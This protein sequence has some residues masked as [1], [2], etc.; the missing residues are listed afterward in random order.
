MTALDWDVHAYFVLNGALHDAAIAAWEIKRRDAS[1]RPITLIRVMGRYGQSSDPSLP[2][3]HTSGLPLVPGLIEL[4]TSESI[5]SGRHVGLERHLGK[6]VVRGWRGEPGDRVRGVGGVTWIRAVEWLPYQRRTFVTPAFPGY[7]SG[8]STFSR[9]ASEV[10][11]AI[12]G[13][14][15]FPGGYAYFEAKPG[16]LTFEYGPSAPVRLEWASYFDAADQAGQSRLWGGIHVTPDDFR[17]R[18]LGSRV[19]LNALT[20]ARSFF[21]P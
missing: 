21:A 18:V 19:G 12:T 4:V 8:H 9:A 17:G 11:S 15:Y 2:S 14:P 16:Y 6:V 5:A 1:A 3:Y 10:L 13:S 7:V 20:R